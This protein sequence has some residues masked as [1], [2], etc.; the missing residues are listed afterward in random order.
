MGVLAPPANPSVGARPV[1]ASTST[2]R[3]VD[4]VNVAAAPARLTTVSDALSVA[5]GGSSP[6]PEM[7]ARRADRRTGSDTIT[8]WQPAAVQALT[9]MVAA[10]CSPDSGSTIPIQ[11]T[12]I[13]GRSAPTEVTAVTDDDVALDALKSEPNVTNESPLGCSAAS[14]PTTEARALA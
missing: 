7:T 13:C 12:P 4:A 1:G 5:L 8:A 6:K 11:T 9:D 3:A 14:R 2:T 10:S